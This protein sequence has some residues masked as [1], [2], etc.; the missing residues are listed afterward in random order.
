[1]LLLP[2][3]RLKVVNDQTWRPTNCSVGAATSQK[4]NSTPSTTTSAR[5]QPGA[6]GWPSGAARECLRVGVW[7]NQ[8][9]A[10]PRQ[11]ES[12]EARLEDAER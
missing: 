7:A 2:C 1:M 8:E 6:I 10:G 11:S 9:G 4:A 12:W 3:A 5:G